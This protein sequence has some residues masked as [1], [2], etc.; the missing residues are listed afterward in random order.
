M[1]SEG[2]EAAAVVV[3]LAAAAVRVTGDGSPITATYRN[4]C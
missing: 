1:G 3:V 4:E 2:I